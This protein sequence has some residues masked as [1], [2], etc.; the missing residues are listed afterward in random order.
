MLRLSCI[1]LFALL[2][3][4]SLVVA[5]TPN[6]AAVDTLTKDVAIA[7]FSGISQPKAQE[8]HAQL[9]ACGDGCDPQ[10]V[11]R[12][13]GSW[14]QVG[15][16]MQE[17]ATI[18]NTATFVAMSPADANT[19]I[20]KQ[21][22]QFYAKYK[23]DKN[24]GKPLNPAVQAQ[25]LAKLDEMLTPVPV[26][27]PV[28]AADNT[29]AVSGTSADEDTGITP[30]AIQLSQLERQTKAA[31]EKQLWMMIL[32]AIVGLI[33]GAGAVYLLAYR[34]LKN[35]VDRLNNE[36]N[37]LSRQF[38]SLRNKTVMATNE[39]RQPQGQGDLRQK[40]NAYDAVLAELGTDNALMA[41]RQ[42]KQQT[43]RSVP[44]TAK[45]V[46]SGEPVIEPN[47][48]IEPSPVQTQP[49][50]VQTPTKPVEAPLAAR[51]EVFYFPPPDP[52]GQFDSQ[53]KSETLS[54]ESAYRFSI[55]A[56]NP[57][58]ATFRFEAEPGRVARFLT[59]RNYMVE[60][61]CESEN[62]FSSTYTR[63]TM[64]RD[65]EAILEN[66][67]WRVKTKAQIRYE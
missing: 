9:L 29:S 44:P 41:I 5:Q 55:N 15:V 56:T 35:E 3:S 26:A 25:L 28:P 65:G 18:K 42:L 32:G 8:I 22:A 14:D 4:A 30:E 1:S 46:R 10:Q 50:P 43:S 40:A 17:L 12:G 11:I 52:T 47:Q 63:I 48:Q 36:N 57:S 7:V 19:A 61:A 66:G 51:S 2:T 20:R 54:P 34:S 58:V 37:K 16:K 23:S 33:V 59:Y 39:P 67:N 64:R 31:E 62:S 38:D 24:Y 53:Q 21:L 6:Q 60:P 27:E 13:V 49:M 45:V